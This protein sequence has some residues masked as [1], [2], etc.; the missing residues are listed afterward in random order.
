[1]NQNESAMI[2][3]RDGTIRA[4]DENELLPDG[5]SLLTSLY[6]RDQARAGASSTSVR[7]AERDRDEAYL[8][9]VD[10]LSDGWKAPPLPSPVSDRRP[11]QTVS[12]VDA[13]LARDAAHR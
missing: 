12:A 5:A 1:M 6:M 7:D 4:L 2:R 8:S 3:L 13:Q 9:M 10:R 11:P